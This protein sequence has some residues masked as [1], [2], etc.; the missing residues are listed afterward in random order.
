MAKLKLEWSVDD[1]SVTKKF[2][3]FRAGAKEGMEESVDTLL[4]HGKGVARERIMQQRRVWNFEVYNEWISDVSSKSDG[5]TGKLV[6][7]APHAGVVN[8]GR[9]P[10][11]APQ[12]QHIIDWVDDNV[13]PR[14]GPSGD[15]TGGGGGGDGGDSGSAASSIKIPNYDPLDD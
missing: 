13:M 2:R 5:V 8:Y 7:V 11:R 14:G 9:K 15:V 12:A 6:A 10:G 4:D 3:R 1:K